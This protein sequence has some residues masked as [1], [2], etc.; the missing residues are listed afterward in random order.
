MMV[1]VRKLQFAPTKR[2][3]PQNARSLVRRNRAAAN[4]FKHISQFR[5]LH[6]ALQIA[7]AGLVASQIKGDPAIAKATAELHQFVAHFHRA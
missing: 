1:D 4:A 5:F 6:I 7:A 2:A 3:G